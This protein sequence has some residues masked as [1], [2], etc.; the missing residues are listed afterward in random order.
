MHAPRPWTHYLN[1]FTHLPFRSI[2]SPRDPLIPPPP[3]HSPSSSSSFS[4]QLLVFCRLFIR[5][6]C[7]RGIASRLR[8]R[9]RAANRQ[10]HAPPQARSLR[11]PTTA[12]V[13]LRFLDRK[14]Y[15]FFS[16]TRVTIA[17]F[18]WTNICKDHG[19]QRDHDTQFARATRSHSA[20]F[21]I[22][23]RGE[24]PRGVVTGFVRSS[25]NNNERTTVR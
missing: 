5:S 3:P 16:T 10:A 18:K 19:R 6:Y 17:A 20:L 8:S 2:S 22:E 15:I 12:H 25:R 4:R 11:G 9:G 1:S 23:M 7:T 13:S 14:L 21:Y 24:M